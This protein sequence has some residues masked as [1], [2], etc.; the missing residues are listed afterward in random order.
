MKRKQSKSAK[1]LKNKPRRAKE[2][3]CET[4]ID[5]AMAHFF[6]GGESKIAGFMHYK[7]PRW[8]EEYEKMRVSDL[9]RR[10]QDDLGELQARAYPT[11]NDEWQQKFAPNYWQKF[12]ITYEGRLRTVIHETIAESLCPGLMQRIRSKDDYVSRRALKE[13]ARLAERLLAEEPKHAANALAFITKLT[14]TYLENL[15]TKRSALM[16]EVAAKYDLWPVNLGRRVRQIKGKRMYEVSRLAF[17][18]NYL[19]ELEL[20]SQCHFPSQHESGA[21]S[22]SPFRLAAEELYIKMLLLKRAPVSFPKVTPWA[23]RLFALRVPMTKD[24]SAGWWRVGKDY[25]YERWEKARVEFDPLI[26]YRGLENL[27][28]KTPYESNIKTRIIDNELKQAFDALAAR[29]L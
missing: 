10:I 13:Y 15:F 2:K 29:D 11:Y 19:I 21:Q 20:N 9:V 27:S 26:Q 28:H 22:V 23:K 12:P 5:K 14:A 24:N 7:P 25:L 18:R 1:L 16:R 6:L 17:A 4:G 8:T 3:R